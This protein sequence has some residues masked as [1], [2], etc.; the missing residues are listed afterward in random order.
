MQDRTQ[1]WLCCFWSPLLWWPSTHCDLSWQP[2]ISVVRVYHVLCPLWFCDDGKL[3]NMLKLAFSR[4]CDLGTYTHTLRTLHSQSA[5]F[6]R[7]GL[8]FRALRH[9]QIQRSPLSLSSLELQVLQTH[10]ELLQKWEWADYSGPGRRRTICLWL[11]IV[12]CRLHF[13]DH[14]G[15]VWVGWTVGQAYHISKVDSSQ[16]VL[17][18]GSKWLPGNWTVV[19]CRCTFSRLLAIPYFYW[20]IEHD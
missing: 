6:W 10:A 11:F 9:W 17:W 2:C 19:D 3:V 5:W 1:P 13:V 7:T 12:V 18:L 8:L 16:T 20:V 14:A 15:G 4:T